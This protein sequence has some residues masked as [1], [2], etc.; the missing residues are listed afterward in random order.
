MLFHPNSKFCRSRVNSGIHGPIRTLDGNT[1]REPGNDDQ[2]VSVVS[3]R[4]GQR[5]WRQHVERFEELE[6]GG[7]HSHDRHWPAVELNP[8]TYDLR[9]APK[10]AGPQP[11][12]DNRGVR[13]RRAV[14]L[15][16]KIPPYH[17]THSQSLQE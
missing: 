12:A 2:I 3:D 6:I 11:I 9:V 7:E 1:W 4:R 5:Q 13:M 16:R 17:R 15:I 14:L 8:S 10:L